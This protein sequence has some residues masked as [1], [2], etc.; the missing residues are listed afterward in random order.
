MGRS[1][2]TAWGRKSDTRPHTLV[3]GEGP[4]R[5]ANGQPQPDCERCFWTIHANTWEEAMAVHN[6]R[7]GFMPYHP[8]PAAD[9]PTCGATIYPEGS[10]RCWSCDL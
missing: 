5:F 1:V 6:L 8:G 10:G 9:C 2:Y 7:Q 4:P 3:G